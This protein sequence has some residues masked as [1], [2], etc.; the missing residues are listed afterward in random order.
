MDKLAEPEIL[1]NGIKIDLGS[2][3]W[4]LFTKSWGSLDTT[5]FRNAQDT[6]AL[7]LLLAKVVDWNVPDAD[8]NPL[9]FEKDK[10]IGQLD[11][12]IAYQKKADELRAQGKYVEVTQ[13]VMPECF[14]IPT[15]LQIAMSSAFYTACGVSYRVPFENSSPHS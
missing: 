10:L 2:G 7:K 11:A 13:E 8:W 3:Y 5:K 4:I 6:V 12:L 1:D 15:P 9:K 14:S